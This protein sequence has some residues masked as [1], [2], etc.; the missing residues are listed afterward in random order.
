MPRR[1]F[2]GDVEPLIQYLDDGHDIDAVFH[3]LTLLQWAC[4]WSD[5][6]VV[7]LLVARRS[8]PDLKVASS[9]KTALMLAVASQRPLELV[10]LLIGASASLDSGDASGNTALMNACANS[11]SNSYVFASRF[12]QTIAVIEAIVKGGADLGVKNDLGRTAVTYA[13]PNL[14]KCPG[15]DGHAITRLVA[16]S[17]MH[18]DHAVFRDA[19]GDGMT[20]LLWAAYRGSAG[21]AASCLDAGADVHAVGA[22]RARNPSP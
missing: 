9:G 5:T 2:H 4:S 13:W 18:V 10:T 7:E 12:E 14:C 17:G 8:N 19:Y 1:R 16:A 20:L 15:Q 3:G 21:F 11:R 22:C 6:A